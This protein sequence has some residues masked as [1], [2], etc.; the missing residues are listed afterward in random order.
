VAAWP[1]SARPSASRPPSRYRYWK[2]QVPER[3]KEQPRKGTKTM[4]SRTTPDPVFILRIHKACLRA[5]GRT[6]S[7]PVHR[8]TCSDSPPSQVPTRTSTAH[9]CASRVNERAVP[10]RRRVHK[11]NN[12]AIHSRRSTPSVSRCL[13]AVRASWDHALPHHCPVH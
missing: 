13:G 11:A 4:R 1:G 6:Y 2:R 7:D 10:A 8:N 3:N 5:Q 9:Q 12:S